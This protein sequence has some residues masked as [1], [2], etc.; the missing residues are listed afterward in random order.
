MQNTGVVSAAQCGRAEFFRWLNKY[1]G[2][3]ISVARRLKVLS[4]SE[5]GRSV[6]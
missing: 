4:A 2:M 1:S 5:R 3:D 6:F